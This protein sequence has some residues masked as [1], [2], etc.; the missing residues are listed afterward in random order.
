MASDT[1]ALAQPGSRSAA[2]ASRAVWALTLPAIGLALLLYLLACVLPVATV[3]RAGTRYEG[4]WLLIGGAFAFFS[5]QFGWCANPLFLVG[6]VTLL[7]R[8][9]RA[10]LALSAVSLFFALNALLAYWV[11]VQLPYSTPYY[12]DRLHLG[13]F[14]WV[15]SMVVIGV[16]AAVGFVM[17]RRKT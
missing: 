5:F 8:R 13:Y 9:W 16:A 2:P 1:G 4:Y 14:L 10:T 11:P 17:H 15:A 3:G 6:L 12:I 7:L